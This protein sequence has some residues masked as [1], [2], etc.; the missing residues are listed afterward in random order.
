[1]NTSKNILITGGS[2][3]LGRTLT[4]LLQ[5][6]GYSVSWLVRSTKNSNV[7]QYLWDISKREIDP[8]ALSDKQIIIHL[9]GE[10]VGEKRITQKIKNQIFES[11]IKSTEL[12]IDALKKE[13]LPPKIF[14]SASAAGYYGAINSEKV[15]S[16][17]DV[18]GNDFMA[19]TCFHW[20]KSVNEHLPENMRKVIFRIGIVL[21]KDAGAFP[22]MVFP[23]K[24]YLGAVLGSG[25]Q[26][27]SWIHISDMC[28]MIIYAI[29]NEQIN[30]V[31]NAVAPEIVSNHQ[32]THQLANALHKKVL[33]PPVPAILLKLL[34]GEIAVSL[35]NG[36][37]I[38]SRKIIEAGYNFQFP[39]LKSALSDLSA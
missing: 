32:F 33:L 30:G 9:A 26:I 18:C 5:A 25:K 36:P 10:N 12:L 29:E 17:V 24:Y 22:R 31:Y 14:I 28:N 1:M 20:E 34:F 11:R 6:K 7:K 15:L 37:P 23:T 39:D 3:L 4:K 38:S 13:N 21:S 16:E 8:K 2:G 35:L 19:K 27:F